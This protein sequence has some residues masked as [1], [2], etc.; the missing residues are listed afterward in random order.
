MLCFFVLR[1]MLP[2]ASGKVQRAAFVYKLSLIDD[3][4]G[5]SSWR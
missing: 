1:K 3:A 5:I 4:G 2:H